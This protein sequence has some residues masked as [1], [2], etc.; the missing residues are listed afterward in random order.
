M[1]KNFLTSVALTVVAF[2]VATEIAIAADITFSGKIRSRYEYSER[3]DFNDATD[4]D[5]VI[6]TQVRLNAHANINT[7]ANSCPYA[8]SYVSTN[9]N[10]CSRHKDWNYAFVAKHDMAKV[11]VTFLPRR[12]ST[13]HRRCNSNY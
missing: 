6:A 9:A 3:N 8:Y 5:D 10:S 2:F 4:A 7:S 11:R 1:K 13:R 12:A